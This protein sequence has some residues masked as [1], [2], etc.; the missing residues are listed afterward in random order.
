[1]IKLDHKND[2]TAILEFNYEFDIYCRLNHPNILQLYGEGHVPRKFIVLEYCEGGIL[3]SKLEKTRANTSLFRPRSFKMKNL[4]TAAIE[5]A[6]ALNYLHSDWNSEATIIHRDLKPDNIGFDANGHIKLFD[7]GLSICVNKLQT[8][9]DTYTMTGYTGSL[10][11]M[12]PEVANSSP[13]NEAAD[14]YSYG[15]ILWQMAHDDLP[16]KGY[17]KALF[18]EAV[19]KGQKRPQ[20][21]IFLPKDLTKLCKK[22]WVKDFTL[23]PSFEEILVMLG[24]LKK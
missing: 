6:S 12:A 21:S 18:E 13:Y 16:F 2:E 19:S 9:Q 5:M 14:V 17:S 1:M 24:K 22:C 23:R 15:L 7:F 3:A 10:R 8:M 4:I 11:Y 20:C